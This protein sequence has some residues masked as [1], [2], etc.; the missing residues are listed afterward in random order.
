VFSWIAG[1]DRPFSA[2]AKE[3]LKSALID[4]EEAIEKAPGGKEYLSSWCNLC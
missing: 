4:I 3:A 2:E 1:V